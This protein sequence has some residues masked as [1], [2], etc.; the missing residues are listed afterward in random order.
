M[1]KFDEIVQPLIEESIAE[2]KA[3]AQ[4]DIKV[5][6]DVIEEEIII[7]SDDP[8]ELL[9]LMMLFGRGKNE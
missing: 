7:V 6:E 4:K 3:K 1:D 8:I 2:E 9:L 5:E